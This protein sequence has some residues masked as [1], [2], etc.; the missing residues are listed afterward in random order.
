M[1]APATLPAAVAVR[2]IY[3]MAD[4]ERAEFDQLYDPRAVDRENVVQPP[5]SRI[6]GPAGF[7]ATALWLRAAFADLRYEVHDVVADGGLVAV[8]STMLGRHVRPIAFW[9]EDAA[10]DSVF[11]PTGRPFAMSQ[12]HWF[13]VVDGR[14][15]EH[16][17]NRDDLGTARQL[18]W[19][20][21]TP[22]YLLRMAHAKRAAVRAAR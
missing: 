22:R 9:T 6:P 8:R 11:P 5:A 18:G 3:A 10:V 14:I 4:G 1:A 20:P 7:H 2:S 12:T 21:P 19:L 13:C 16:R 17:A 15:R